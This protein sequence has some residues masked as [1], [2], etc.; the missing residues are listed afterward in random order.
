[1]NERDF[2]ELAEVIEEVYFKLKEIEEALQDSAMRFAELEER[3]A[4]LERVVGPKIREA[5]I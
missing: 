4:A 5:D 3:V 2:D 1:V